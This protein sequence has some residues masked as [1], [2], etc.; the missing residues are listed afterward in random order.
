MANDLVPHDQYNHL[1]VDMPQSPPTLA[2][3]E[4]DT[5]PMLAM[6]SLDDMQEAE[7][8]QMQPWNGVEDAEFEMLGASPRSEQAPADMSLAN[9]DPDDNA[10]P[11]D[12]FSKD[13][14][15]DE[16]EHGSDL[17]MTS[18]SESMPSIAFDDTESMLTPPQ[19]GIVPH[20][21]ND[22]EIDNWYEN[23]EFHT[24]E[25]NGSLPPLT[26]SQGTPGITYQPAGGLTNRPAPGGVIDISSGL[27]DSARGV[28][29]LAGAD[30]VGG[31]AGALSNGFGF[32]IGL[33]AAQSAVELIRNIVSATTTTGS[34]HEYQ[35]GGGSPGGNPGGGGAAIL[36]A[37]NKLAG[38]K[39]RM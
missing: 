31:A 17:A 9:R 23:A 33:T 14:E 22:N 35:I 19:A 29:D 24:V 39:S 1:P 36:A 30:A 3:P 15:L 13:A 37:L 25:P 11:I 4:P 21:G 5:S 10:N 12:V 28:G 27:A 38:T 26:G 16:M 18:T 2:E 34:I 20:E 6:T 32:G 8:M 7:F